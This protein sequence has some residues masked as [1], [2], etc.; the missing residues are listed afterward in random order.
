VIVQSDSSG[1]RAVD[2]A[3]LVC[4]PPRAERIGSGRCFRQSNVKRV[5]G[6]FSGQ[7]PD[8]QVARFT[9]YV[10]AAKFHC[11]TNS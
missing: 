4:E 11:E 3:A 7:I 2:S 5:A 8:L 6:V 10:R 1:T 9:R